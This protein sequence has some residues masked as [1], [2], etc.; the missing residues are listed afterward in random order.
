M[1][2]A[3]AN[4]Y[5][6]SHPK[7]WLGTAYHSVLE[8]LAQE[9]WEASEVLRM[10]DERWRDAVEKAELR[11]RSHQLNSRYDGPE[12][13]PGYH[14][15]IAT[16]RL[17]AKEW[18]TSIEADRTESGA[19]SPISNRR[20]RLA[21]RCLTAFEGRLVGYPDLVTSG[22]V[23]DYKT[24]DV[25]EEDGSGAARVKAAYVSQLKIYGYLVFAE[26]RKWPRQGV[27]LPSNGGRVAV[28]LNEEECTA[29]A[30][31]AVELLE[32]YNRTVAEPGS[33]ASDL[34][35][36][37]PETCRWCGYK[38][39]CPAFWSN[40]SPDWADQAGEAL[41]GMLIDDPLVATGETMAT[42]KVQPQRGSI[43]EADATIGRFP[44][45]WHESLKRLK[46]R[47]QVR[48]T[49]LWRRPDGSVQVTKRTVVLA[50]TDIPDIV[51]TPG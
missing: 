13:W 33:I 46:K 17:R 35:R 4:T 30:R 24:G 20:A 40:I 48:I 1:H 2:A 32:K 15:T 31:E 21:E 36:P 39:L 14:I 16:L 49:G 18:V 45:G 26:T 29:A 47:S 41:E 38:M 25:F 8:A 50:L 23:Y 34:A 19:S 43:A 51:V 27:L 10:V 9:D 11:V 37:S 6:L 28:E 7:A 3:G 12:T 22:T 42:I 5:V 44:V